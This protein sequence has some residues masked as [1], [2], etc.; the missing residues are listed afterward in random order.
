M[1]STNKST[2]KYNFLLYNCN[3]INREKLFNNLIN[4]RIASKHFL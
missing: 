1:K 2:N 3:T 4:K